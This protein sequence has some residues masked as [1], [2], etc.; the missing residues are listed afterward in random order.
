[1]DKEPISFKEYVWR[2]L[3]ALVRL[4]PK[5][6]DSLLVGTNHAVEKL[7]TWQLEN[8]LNRLYAKLGRL[9]YDRLVKNPDVTCLTGDA[10]SLVGE[11]T[12]FEQEL[13][14]RKLSH[15][16]DRKDKKNDGGY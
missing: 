3:D 13:A 12:I 6:R 5:A 4:G 15:Q 16:I 1:M 14:L 11:I 8:K 9:S 2:G 7:D 10:V